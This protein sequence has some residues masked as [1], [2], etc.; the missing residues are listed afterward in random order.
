MYNEKIPTKQLTTW[1]CGAILP[2]WIQLAAGESWLTVVVTA[3]LTGAAVWLVWRW[4]RFEN[5][6]LLGLSILFQVLLL[7]TLMP[8][9]ARIWPGGNQYPAVPLGILALSVWSAWKGPRAAAAVGC[10]LFWAV[11]VGNLLILGAGVGVMELQW[12]RPVWTTPN[13]MIILLGLLPSAAGIWKLKCSRWSARL[14]LPSVVTV[15][16]CVATVGVLSMRLAGETGNSFL[17]LSQSVSLFGIARHFEAVGSAIMTAG[18]FLIVTLLLCLCAC[19]AEKLGISKA[20]PVIPACALV[21]ALWMLCE[22]HISQEILLVFGAVCW[23]F[24]PLLPQGIELE[25]KS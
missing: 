1:L 25:K 8:Y 13:P 22:M 20:R 19:H 4:G 15:F 12:L 16:A 2:V 10:V 18:W 14:I 23:V 11:L 6:I 21:S 7:G 9:A 5:K 3:L 24:A 17:E